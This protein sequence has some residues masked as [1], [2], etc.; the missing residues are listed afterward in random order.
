MM[1]DTNKKTVKFAL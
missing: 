1:F